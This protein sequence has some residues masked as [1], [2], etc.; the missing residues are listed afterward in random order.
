MRIVGFATAVLAVG[1]CLI[2][3]WALGRQPELTLI[4]SSWFVVGLFGMVLGSALKYPWPPHWTAFF[5]AVALGCWVLL[6]AVQSNQ[7]ADL[8]SDSWFYDAVATEIASTVPLSRQINP[9]EFGYV[10]DTGIRLGGVIKD[11]G[12]YKVLGLL[13]TLARAAGA[14]PL[15]VALALINIGSFALVGLGLMR[16]LLRVSQGSLNIGVWSLW[17]AFMANPFLLDLITL[18]RKDLLILVVFLVGVEALVTRKLRLLAVSAAVL[19]TL[20]LEQGAL[21]GVGAFVMWACRFNKWVRVFGRSRMARL[22]VL[23]LP[24]LLGPIVG[25]IL[26]EP[27]PEVL[28]AY[29]RD[30]GEASFGLSSLLQGSIWGAAA[31][32]W[33]YPFP[34]VTPGSVEEFIRSGFALVWFA[35]TTASLTKVLAGFGRQRTG[36]SQNGARNAL[37][38]MFLAAFAGLCLLTIAT[39]ALLGFVVIETRYKLPVWVLTAVLLRMDSRK[40]PIG[41]KFCSPRQPCAIR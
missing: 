19:G 40:G 38:W 21:L 11:P 41:M 12:F 22:L 8:R 29:W 3:A 13:Y 6:F 2:T 16:L 17:A 35:L 14:D 15:L 25:G 33:G 37:E 4:L 5:A 31:Y 23:G 34:S 7:V 30:L 24:F 27:A 36:W 18:L 28:Q 26:G 10:R 20:R 32:A 9:A 39:S 1:A